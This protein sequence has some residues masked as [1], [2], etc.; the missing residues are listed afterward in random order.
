MS[1]P[2]EKERKR[3][4]MKRSAVVR[5]LHS[6]KYR[7]R[8]VRDRRR[9]NNFK[10]FEEDALDDS[11]SVDSEYSDVFDNTDMELDFDVTKW[12]LDNGKDLPD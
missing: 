3:Q 5:D 9:D 1:T 8:I 10:A 6:P 11:S 2:E 7:Q 4:R 12:E